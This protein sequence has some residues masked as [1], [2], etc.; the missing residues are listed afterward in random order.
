MKQ[1]HYILILIIIV[2]SNSITYAQTRTI[3][4]EGN[5]SAAGSWLG[6]NIANS[7]SND[8]ITKTSGNPK[9]GNGEIITVDGNYS[10]GNMTFANQTLTLA[11]PNTLNLGSQALFDA[12]TYKNFTATNNA[13]IN[14]PSGATMIIYGD[15]NAVNGLKINVEGTF[16]V[17]GDFT[18]G[19]NAGI[20]V[21]GSGTIAVDGDLSLGGGTTS[22]T[23]PPG[24][25]YVGGTCSAGNGA[26]GSSALPI[27]LAYFK[28]IRINDMVKLNWKTASEVNNDYYSLERS[29]D[30]LEYELISTLPGAGN[31]SSIL[32]YSYIDRFP[33]FGRSYYRLSQTDFDGTSETFKPIT[34]EV[35]S[36]VEGSKLKLSNNPA[37]KGDVLTVIT[38]AKSGEL[39]TITVHNMLGEVIL[40]DQFANSTYELTVNNN[41]RSGVYLVTVSSINSKKITRLVVK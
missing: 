9:F 38:S 20:V 17:K 39:L 1:V 4:D 14:V 33:L 26:C 2:T 36:L 37:N 23:G 22:I 5:W 15:L 40:T 29:V 25:I 19:N 27:E 30:G 21:S 41:I 28:A 16:T 12:A 18:A 13:T 32:E 6:G 8:V 24:S 10:V 34:V 35:T 31:S 7:I 11:S 3:Q